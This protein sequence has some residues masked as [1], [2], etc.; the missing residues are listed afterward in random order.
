MNIIPDW[1]VLI[2]QGGG[3]ILLLI[4]FK[5]FLFK[6]IFGILDARRQEIE[7]R[8][9]DAEAERKTADDLKA[10]YEQRLLAV[11]EEIR[12]KIT[13]AIKEGQAMREEILS[14]SRSRADAILTK[15]QEEIQ[16]ERNTAMQELKTTV[17]NLA[18]DAAGKLIEANLTTDKQ[19][20]L[21][22]GF[23]DDLD[24]VSR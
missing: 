14:E 11:E 9:N 2:V 24:E 5:I 21:V 1:R 23:I 6:P 8:Y 7:G 10:Q 12:G 17:A 18:V 3:F 16:R 22:D 15:A 13:E 19:R 4:I 20:K